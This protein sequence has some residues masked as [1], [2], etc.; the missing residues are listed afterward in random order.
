[1]RVR[2]IFAPFQIRARL[3]Y[4]ADC[5]NVMKHDWDQR[6]A[7]D[8][9]WY[10]NTVRRQQSE[11]EFDA[12][13]QHEVQCQIVDALPLL[14][15]DRD[16]RQ[17]RLLEIGCGIGRMTKHL[18]AIFGE[19]YA[20]DVSA[21]MIRQAQTRLSGLSNVRL[22][23]TSGQDFALFPDQ[24]FDVVFSAYVFQ[25]IPSA[26][27]IHSNLVEGFRVLKRGGVFK[28][29]TNGISQPAQSQNDSWNGAAFPEDQLRQ[30]GRALGVQLLGLFGE[31]TQYCWT[32]WRR[33]TTPQP[34]IRASVPQLLQ[35]GHVD[36]LKQQEI[37]LDGERPYLTL[38]LSG[39]FSEWD[40]ADTLVIEVGEARL[41]P[42]YAGPPGANLWAT[43]PTHNPNRLFQI[44]VRLDSR[45]T[46][47]T[48]PV[49]VRC[50]DGMTSN[51]IN[52]R[53]NSNQL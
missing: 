23:E 22:F 40:D 24:S 6:A 51:S 9:R 48:Q 32:M 39:E 41:Q 44:N 2:Q 14:T 33:R 50:A 46:P 30:L 28:F 52:I 34:P 1:M 36:D 4:S 42:R 3:R 45:I 11:A 16:P 26:A 5:M 37:A 35:V 12:S 29:V 17:L 15:G 8:A 43:L 49:R 38:V 25:H 10:I 7:D 18:A 31:E 21:E 53:L 47:G 19:V 13:G 20:V 27:I